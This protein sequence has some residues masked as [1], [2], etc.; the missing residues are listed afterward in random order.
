MFPEEVAS[1]DVLSSDLHCEAD[2]DLY[3]LP[4]GSSKVVTSFLMA[5]MSL[6]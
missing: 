4:G 5:T 6:L 3:D 1:T 2:W